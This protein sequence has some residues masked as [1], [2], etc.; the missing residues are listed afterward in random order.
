[1][2]KEGKDGLL[3]SSG[4]VYNFRIGFFLRCPFLKYL[5]SNSFLFLNLSVLDCGNNLSEAKIL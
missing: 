5:C 1:M 2:E 4:M 3:D